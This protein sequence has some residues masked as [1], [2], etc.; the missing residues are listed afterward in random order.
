MLDRI[1]A[2]DR[3][4]CHQGM[5]RPLY[6]EHPAGVRITGSPA[7]YDP[8]IEDLVPFKADG[9]PADLC[10]GWAARSRALIG[11]RATT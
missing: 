2:I 3:F 5:R 10:A 6:W 9:T 7:D 4:W 11:K 1:A 8:P